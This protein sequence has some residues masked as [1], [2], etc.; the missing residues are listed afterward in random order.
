MIE[1]CQL[2]KSRKTDLCFHHIMQHF[3]TIHTFQFQ[4]ID[5][6]EQLEASAVLVESTHDEPDEDTESAFA[7]LDLLEQQSVLKH[8]GCTIMRARSELQKYGRAIEIKVDSGK[9][10]FISVEYSMITAV[11]SCSRT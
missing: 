10:K 3:W 1:I 7:S 9:D 8:A 6:S 5:H 2:P 11:V 4:V